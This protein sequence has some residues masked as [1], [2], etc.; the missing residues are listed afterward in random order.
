MSEPWGWKATVHI[1]GSGPMPH[2]ADALGELANQLAD[3]L[4]ADDFVG[5]DLRPVRDQPND[6]GAA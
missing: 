2:D 1:Y 5:V 4:G 6:Q 3:K